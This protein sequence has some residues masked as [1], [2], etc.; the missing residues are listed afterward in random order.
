M[1]DRGAP[2]QGG[3]GVAHRMARACSRAGR[4]AWPLMGWVAGSSA[5]GRRARAKCLRGLWYLFGSVAAEGRAG[6]RAGPWKVLAACD[7]AAP[8]AFS[9]CLGSDFAFRGE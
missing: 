1:A 3:E 4:R 9:S 6:N 5:P 7:A 8:R 2:G